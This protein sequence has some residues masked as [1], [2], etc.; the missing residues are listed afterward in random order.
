MAAQLPDRILINGVHM[1]LYS[2]PL[3]QYW[4]RTDKKRPKFCELYECLRGYVANWEIK[5]NQLFLRDIDGNFEKKSIFFG[6]ESARYSIKTLFPKAK[7][8]PVKASWFSGKLRIPK[9]KMTM[10]AHNEYDSRFEN[11]IIV[12]IEK[13]N[14]IKMVTIDYNKKVLIVNAQLKSKVHP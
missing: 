6:V 14:V 4:I 8:R 11:E 9:G 2:N 10:Y 13:G 5:E 7:A 3:E 12:T 1:N